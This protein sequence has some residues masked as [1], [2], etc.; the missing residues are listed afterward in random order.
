MRVY[1]YEKYGY[2]RPDAFG[3]VEKWKVLNY[4]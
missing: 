4:D 1:G 3:F 2:I